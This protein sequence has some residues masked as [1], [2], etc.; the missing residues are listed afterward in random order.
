MLDIYVMSVSEYDNYIVSSDDEDSITDI[1][2]V[3]MFD[4]SDS[5]V[6]ISV[7][8]MFLIY[9][10]V[11]FTEEGQNLA[12]WERNFLQEKYS[13]DAFGDVEW[14]YHEIDDFIDHPEHYPL[15]RPKIIHFGDIKV[16]IEFDNCDDIVEGT[17]LIEMIRTYFQV[18]P[19]F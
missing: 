4:R 14:P 15:H 18:Y 3:Y 17:A 10:K 7:Y 13:A 16:G 12:E 11:I 5:T 19:P 9:M 1:R 6:G 8:K 2:G